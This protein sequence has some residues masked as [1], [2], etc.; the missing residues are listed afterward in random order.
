MIGNTAAVFEHADDLA[1]VV[2]DGELVERAGGAANDQHDVRR[3]D[4]DDV[5]PFVAETGINNHIGAVVGQPI[6]P[7]MLPMILRR[8]DSKSKTAMVAKCLSH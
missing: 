7:D 5:A 3:A 1:L 6:A 8:R 2:S 4:V